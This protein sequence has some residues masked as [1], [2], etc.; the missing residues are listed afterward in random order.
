MRTGKKVGPPIRFAR[1][2]RT[3]PPS[4]WRPSGTSVWVSSFA[5][6]TRHPHQSRR[7]A[8]AAAGSHA[9]SSRDVDGSAARCPAAARSSPASPFPGRGAFAVGEGAVWAMSD[10]TST[11]L[12]I[13][14]T[15][16]ASSRGSRSARA[17]PPPPGRARSGCPTRRGHGLAH[18]PA[19]EQGVATIHVGP[20]PDGNRGL[21]G[22]VW[23]AIGWTQRRPHRPGDEP[24]RGD[25]QGRAPRDV[26]CPSTWAVRDGRRR[27]GRPSP[28]GNKLVRIDPATNSRH[29]DP[30]SSPIAPCG[31]LAADERSSGRR[32]EAARDVVARIDPRTKTLTSTSREPHP[33]GLGSPSAPSGSPCSARATSIGSTR[34]PAARGATPVGGIPVM[35]AIGFGSVWVIDDDGR[36]LRID[37]TGSDPVAQGSPWT[38]ARLEGDP[39]CLGAQAAVS[40]ERV[41]ASTIEEVRH[42][43]QSSHESPESSALA[44]A[45]AVVG[46]ASAGR[47]GEPSKGAP[48]RR[49]GDREDRDSTG[50]GAI[51]VGEGA[52]W[53]LSWH[54]SRLTRIDPHGKPS[55]A[56]HQV[57]PTRAVPAVAG[58]LR[59]VAAGNGAVWVS[60]R[61]DN[62]SLA[63]TRG[64]T[65]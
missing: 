32:A 48:A 3:R 55:A 49:H 44:C 30:C 27:S 63:S 4:R 17:T 36:V 28:N 25:D 8:D 59:E 13:D 16:N 5:S 42:E 14:P 34:A 12:R 15:R 54:A 61:T 56:Y 39:R 41:P 31:F 29:R 46:A 37:P 26:L 7:P 38:A 21:A 23:V 10:D 18:R 65:A 57:K 9:S 60:M 51:A 19:N 11:L 43:P 6:D 2:R 40:I 33:V 50:T 58:R 53:V 62:R 47:R 1:R 20:A 22:A 52:V 45:L 64:R 35:L 24:R